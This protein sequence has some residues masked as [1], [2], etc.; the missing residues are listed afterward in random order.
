MLP[1]TF[2]YILLKKWTNFNRQPIDLEERLVGK[3]FKLSYVKN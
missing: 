1:A 3:C 2:D